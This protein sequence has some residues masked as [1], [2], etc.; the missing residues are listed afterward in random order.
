MT[1]KIYE[2]TNPESV[3]SVLGGFSNP[4]L[5]SFNGAAGEVVE[6]LYYVRNDDDTLYYTS[7]EVQPID[8]GDDIVDGNN[9]TEGYNWRL[10]A[11]DQR[12]S[13][14]Q[15]ATVEA[16]AKIDLSDIG[17]AG[18]GSTTTYLPFWVRIGVP[19]DAPVTSYQS[20]VLRIKATANDATI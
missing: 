10:I 9:S 20:V 15:W 5:Q 2:T 16:G 14:S 13:E 18:A 1:L 17:E 8:G 6:V 12:P 4:I 11:G 7:I 3:F 19:E